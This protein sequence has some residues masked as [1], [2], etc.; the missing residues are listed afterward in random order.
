M[1]MIGVA[2]YQEAFLGRLERRL[3][4]SVDGRNRAC[5]ERDSQGRPGINSDESS[6]AMAAL[7]PR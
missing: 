6:T 4:V 2:C 3:P 7:G 5:L 1:Q